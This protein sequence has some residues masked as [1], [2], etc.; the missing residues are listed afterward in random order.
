MQPAPP[1][2]PSGLPYLEALVAT[3]DHG[4]ALVAADGETLLH[5][6]DAFA[7][8]VR[9]EEA[10]LR[11]TSW[12]ALLPPALADARAAQIAA[13]RATRKRVRHR[14]VGGNGVHFEH[15][16]HPIAPR[17]DGEVEVF[18]IV[19]RDLTAERATAAA[20]ERSEA[21]LN[22]AQRLAQLGSWEL[23]LETYELSWSDEIFRMF[24]VDRSRFGASYDSFLAAIH[25]DDRALV[26]A[27]YRTSVETRSPYDIVH[28]LV[29]DGAVRWVQERC[30]TVYDP[31]G[32]PL[33]SRGTVQDVTDRVLAERELR[34]THDLLRAVLDLSPDPISV[35]DREHRY[36]LANRAFAARRGL[37]PEACVGLPDTFFFSREACEGDAARGIPGYHAEDRDVLGGAVIDGRESWVEH[38]DG[39]RH[40]YQTFKAPLRDAQGTIYGV[41]AW[42]RDVTTRH[43][44]EAVLRES[45]AR[46]RAL[47][48][49]LPDA[50]LVNQDERY[51]YANS[52][53]AA[54]LGYDAA[55]Q[56]LGLRVRDVVAPEDLDAVMRV[57]A[58]PTA[59]VAH[60]ERRWRRRDGST[61]TAEVSVIQTVL[62]ARPARVV[63][64]RDAT[65]RK[66]LG[67]R[68]A[69]M[70]RM[71]AVGTL[72]AGVGHEVN[73]P[74]AYVIG[75]LDFAH[76]EVASLLAQGP[77]HAR[78]ADRSVER[79]SALR[80]AL[81]E[82][83]QGADRIRSIVRDLR[84][85]AQ[86]RE[87]EAQRLALP[88]VIGSALN[89]ARGELR[90]RA[91]VVTEF[92]PTPDVYA[93]ESRLA[94]V[95]LNLLV[96]A[97]QA[98]PEG[99]AA[100]NEVRVV[101]RTDAEGRAVVEVDDT[102]AGLA[103]GVAERVF[104]PFFTTK[105]VGVGTGLGLSICRN[106]VRGLGGQVVVVPRPAGARGSCFRVVLPGVTTAPAPPREDAVAAPASRR[107]RVA[108]VDD[109]P[110]VGRTFVRFFVG[111][112]DVE[113]FPC[114][115]GLL[116]RL[117]EGGRF[118]V[119]FCDLMMPEMSGIDLYARMREAFPDQARR[120]VFIT[121]GAFSAD[122][123]A[124][125]DDPAIR[126]VEKP[127][128]MAAIK[129]ALAEVLAAHDRDASPSPPRA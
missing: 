102:G 114:A 65:A 120:V 129:A 95:F 63:L 73:N 86:V 84:T 40:L 77:G 88:A 69:Q 4:A 43:K 52:A 39:A 58:Q 38:P 54:L 85:F 94:Q 107:V 15:L 17:A 82:A 106:I 42:G 27:A 87:G 71:I 35:K 14:D 6:N 7:A 127:F 53:A 3:I 80:C 76:A 92:G 112:H 9:K 93:N 116:A 91:Q 125:L 70:D 67:A 36:L 24:G 23:D 72:A 12:R 117:D 105:P 32:K 1:L 124:F 19:S 20:I 57:R 33:R 83:K 110:L 29:R 111:E 37:E 25:P 75:N 55:G 119:V 5:V 99:S 18:L 48:D 26:D 100:E 101:T 41:L 61:F 56:V 109:E 44:A 28:R 51:V 30:E 21:R 45:E 16:I 113:T 121:G 22:E 104:D 60:V 34:R 128:T 11:G 108:L 2:G 123:Q 64:A 74:L 49:A 98:I 78:E 115:A 62:D 122:A 47:L 118:D 89:L 81:A 79:L 10:A 96:N 97:A 126:Y 103:P 8:L 13:A 90:H 46:F 50:V 68:M 31:A 66:E 59:P